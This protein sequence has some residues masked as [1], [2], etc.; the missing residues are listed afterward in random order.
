[1]CP[2]EIY[3]DIVILVGRDVGDAVPY[4]VKCIFD[5][6]RDKNHITHFAA[7]G[8]PRLSSPTRRMNPFER[9]VEDAVPYKRMTPWEREGRSAPTRKGRYYTKM[10]KMS[11]KWGF[12]MY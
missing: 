12:L 7:G 6:Q 8:T 3:T 5:A 4:N 11:E 9:D 2:T 1:M 10:L